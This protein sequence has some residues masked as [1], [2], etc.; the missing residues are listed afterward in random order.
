LFER[1]HHRRLA[2]V[3]QALEPDVLARCGCWFGGGTAM[4]L[5]YGEYRESLDIDFL[6]S[7][8]GG[9]RELRQMLGGLQGLA[10]IAR[11]GME[12]ELAREVR[13][14]QYGIRTLVRSGGAAIKFEIVFEARIALAVPGDE[15]RVCG[16]TTLTAVDL[17]AEKLLA[18]ADR[19][20]DDAVFSRDLIDLAMQA[21]PPAT[22]KAACGKA[23]AAYGT[24]VRRAIEDAVNALRRRP[25][26]LE[27]CMRA[28]GMHTV[29]RAQLWQRVRRVE[30]ALATSAA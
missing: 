22:L 18:N 21:A 11:H 5:R 14:D 27:E 19:W 10:P 1:E 26:R 23:E 16:L 15:D 4:A 20:P 12:I 30:R 24:S 8:H 13:R 7:D 29:S 17:A 9:Y 3:L 28:L 25:H 2:L 6:V